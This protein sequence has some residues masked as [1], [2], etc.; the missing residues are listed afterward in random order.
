MQ[1]ILPSLDHPDQRPPSY[2]VPPPDTKTQKD[3]KNLNASLVAIKSK[4]GSSFSQEDSHLVI[5]GS[6]NLAASTIKALLEVLECFDVNNHVVN[7]LMNELLEKYKLIK[8]TAKQ[9]LAN[10]D[11]KVAHNDYTDALEQTIKVIKEHVPYVK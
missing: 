2:V 8:T 10:L 9:A 3:I 11:D 7:N 4:V 5:M 1:I 6:A